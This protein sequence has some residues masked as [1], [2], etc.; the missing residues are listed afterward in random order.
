MNTPRGAG[1]RGPLARCELQTAHHSTL[2]ASVGLISAKAT[3]ACCVDAHGTRRGRSRVEQCVSA[4]CKK[5]SIG[6]PAPWAPSQH[7]SRMPDLAGL[8][9]GLSI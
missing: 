4:A 2:T 9:C 3:L 8:G 7:S 1:A 6:R 5:Y